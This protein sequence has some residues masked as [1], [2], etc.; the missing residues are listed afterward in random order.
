MSKSRERFGSNREDGMRRPRGALWSLGDAGSSARGD[1]SV[2]LWEVWNHLKSH[3]RRVGEPSEGEIKQ[4]RLI[5]LSRTQENPT[6]QL[7]DHQNN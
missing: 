5:S 3:R 4:P 7:L 6:G 2:S 1:D